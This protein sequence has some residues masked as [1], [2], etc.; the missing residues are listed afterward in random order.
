MPAMPMP[1]VSAATIQAD[2]YRRD[3]S[4]RGSCAK[5]HQ[6]APHVTPAKTQP[7]HAPKP[8]QP[9]T[10]QVIP[11]SAT[12]SNVGKIRSCSSP[13]RGARSGGGAAIA[14]AGPAAAGP[15][16]AGP[17]E[18]F[19]AKLSGRRPSEQ[20]ADAR[21]KDQSNTTGTMVQPTVTSS[22]KQLS[23]PECAGVCHNFG[24]GRF[25]Q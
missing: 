24:S 9:R 20:V 21:T 19:I 14:V 6:A 11:P 7:F 25:R 13:E 10:A 5:Y 3:C 12:K 18:V 23:E 4:R 8:E 2:A 17:G 22:V 1:N 15:R 16:E